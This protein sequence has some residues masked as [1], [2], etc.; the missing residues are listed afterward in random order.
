M[1]LPKLNLHLLAFI[2]LSVLFPISY[3]QYPLFSSNQNTYFLPGF[4]CAG[5]GNLNHDWL[6]NTQDTSPL[7]SWL[8]CQTIKWVHW[9]G[10]FYLYYGFIQAIYFVTFYKLI[11]YQINLSS[12]ARKSFAIAAIFLIHSAAVRYLL[13]HLIGANWSYILEG[14][15][16]NQ[17][18]LGSVFQ[19]SVFA[20]FLL[21]SVALALDK[22]FKWAVLSLAIAAWFHPTY[23][24]PSG[25]LL[26]TYFIIIWQENSDLVN[27]KS[28]GFVRQLVQL[29]MLYIILISP[30]AYYTISHFG[31][32]IHATA[33]EAADILV[34]VRIPHHADLRTWFNFTSLVQL[35]LI[36]SALYLTRKR[37]LR[38]IIG[39]PFII[40]LT[41]T[42]FQIIT[43]NSQLA[44]LFPW[45]ISVVL[46]PITMSIYSAWLINKLLPAQNPSYTS[47]FSSAK[48]NRFLPYISIGLILI[49]GGIG[50]IRFYLDLKRYNAAPENLLYNYVHEHLSADSVY[51]IPP[52]MENFRLASGAAAFIDFKSSPYRADEVLEW[53]RR[54]TLSTHFYQHPTCSSLS[55]FQREKITHIILPVSVYLDCP[56]LIPEYESNQFILYRLS[57]PDG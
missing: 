36:L 5:V 42:I 50:C 11:A 40:A 57:A 16:A 15:L 8:V 28:D 2:F 13:T 3:T 17:R 24:L 29:T 18:I 33:R 22:R 52:K 1:N 30:I 51:L 38:T 53:Y 4:A 39:I 46:I 19:P 44:L 35:G 31:I 20:V 37:S 7:F 14:G 6:A 54:L 12:F 9:N 43:Q 25:M 23:L 45:R 56:T 41:L 26:L 34:H 21:L 49:C 47:L 27:N 48:F 10:I 32:N 55:A